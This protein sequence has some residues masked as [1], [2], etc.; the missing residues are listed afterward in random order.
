MTESEYEADSKFE[1]Y[2]TR[3]R[4]EIFGIGS[5]ITETDA[6]ITRCR[7]YVLSTGRACNKQFGRRIRP[8]VRLGNM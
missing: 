7:L 1:P 6:K 8:N 5:G 3:Q 4:S 2:S